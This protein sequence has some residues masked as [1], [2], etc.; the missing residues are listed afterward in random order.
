MVGSIH[1]EWKP[2][3]GG[4]ILNTQKQMNWDNTGQVALIVISSVT[5]GYSPQYQPLAEWRSETGDF[6]AS[7]LSAGK[8]VSCWILPSAAY[9]QYRSGDRYCWQEGVKFAGVTTAMVWTAYYMLRKPKGAG[10]LEDTIFTFEI[11][12]WTLELFDYLKCMSD[13]RKAGHKP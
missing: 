9:A 13:A 4:H 8:S 1:S 11:A 7:L 5:Y 2:V 6:F 10:T 12:A 3:Y